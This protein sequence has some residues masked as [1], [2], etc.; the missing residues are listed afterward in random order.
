MLAKTSMLNNLFKI[1]LISPALLGTLLIIVPSR[2]EELEPLDQVFNRAINNSTGTYYDLTSISG[3]LNMFFGWRSWTG[4]YPENEI[5]EDAKTTEFLLK[6][7]MKQ[8]NG[9]AFM[10]KDLVNPYNTSV[11]R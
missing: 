7:A 5:S 11:E 9:E 2:A 1:L 8:Q 6:D 3:Q 10:T 4:S